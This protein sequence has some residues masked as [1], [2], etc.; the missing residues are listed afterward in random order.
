MYLYFYKDMCPFC[1]KYLGIIEKYNAV[2]PPEK[3]IHSVNIF[4]FDPR[5]QIILDALNLDS[6]YELR[7]PILW[8]DGVAIIGMTTESYVEGML[9][10]LEADTT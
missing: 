7:V 3:R 2:V 5:I 10:R 9:K 8:L 1:I 6:V 4:S